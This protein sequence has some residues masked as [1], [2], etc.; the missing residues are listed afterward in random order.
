MHTYICIKFVLNQRIALFREFTVYFFKKVSFR[1]FSGGS[2]VR[3][4]CFHC[5][6]PGSIPGQGTK[7]PQAAWHAPPTRKK[8]NFL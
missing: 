3:T 5:R 2:V 6:G 4:W 1:E 8:V 7:I